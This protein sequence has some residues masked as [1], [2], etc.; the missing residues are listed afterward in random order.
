MKKKFF[1]RWFFIPLLGLF[2]VGNILLYDHYNRQEDMIF[3]AKELPQDYVY[4]TEHPYKENI[5]K[6]GTGS[7]NALLFTQEDS[8]GVVLFCHGRGKNLSLH[9]KHVDGF[10]ARGY[11]VLAFDYRGFGKSSKGFKESWLLE[12]G[13]TCYNYLANLYPEENIVVYG[14]SMG[15]AVATW[16]AKEKNPKLLV[17]ESPFT[18]MIDAAAYTKPYLARWVVSMILKYPLRTDQWIESVN[19][20]VAVLH[21][22]DDTIVPY[23]QG[24]ALFQKIEHRP[25]CRFITIVYNDHNTLY[26]TDAYKS[27]LRKILN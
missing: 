5:L 10:L 6:S 24:K 16:V 9:L 23:S 3:Q 26:T 15:T 22:T 2:L 20:P 14:N 19:C 17:L 18:S 25:N 12:D 13:I 1:T 21:G 27:E 8:K 4:T 7:I 11:D